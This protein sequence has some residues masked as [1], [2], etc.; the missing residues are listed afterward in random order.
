VPQSSLT[1]LA[2]L[3]GIWFI[4]MGILELIGGFVLRS[5][6]HKAGS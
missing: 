5:A 3:L 1:A 2:T 4:V 6:L